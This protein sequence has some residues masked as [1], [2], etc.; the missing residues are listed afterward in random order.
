MAFFT[1]QISVAFSEFTGELILSREAFKDVTEQ[2]LVALAEL[3]GNALRY[4]R[5]LGTKY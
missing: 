3:T 2:I 5:I 1:E 4:E